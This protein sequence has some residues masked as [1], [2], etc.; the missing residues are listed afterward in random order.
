[1]L[2]E[3]IDRSGKRILYFL[4]SD[5]FD[6]IDCSNDVPS[7]VPVVPASDLNTSYIEIDSSSTGPR[8]A[9]SDN[10]WLNDTPTDECGSVINRPDYDFDQHFVRREDFEQF[11]SDISERVHYI[12]ENLK[13]HQ[14]FQQSFFTNKMLNQMRQEILSKDK[15][16][17]MLAEDNEKT[18][19]Q[20]NYEIA[21]LSTE[22]NQ[23]ASFIRK[24]NGWSSPAKD[25]DWSIPKKTVKNVSGTNHRASIPSLL[26]VNPFNCV[27][28]TMTAFLS[29]TNQTNRQL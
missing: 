23:Q 4:L 24:T 3:E 7:V 19:A 20:K 21:R 27:A 1:M 6:L 13:K 28:R 16:I 22:N 17:N 25:N 14:G 12:S 5:N 8:V 2:R 29:Q 26:S 18:I 15:I 9:I 11:K 10:E